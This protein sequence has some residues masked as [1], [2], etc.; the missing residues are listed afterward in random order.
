[1]WNF[2]NKFFFHK[3]TCNIIKFH[4][5]FSS[6]KV[7]QISQRA[8]RLSCLSSPIF[9]LFFHYLKAGAQYR[10]IYS[11]DKTL[12]YVIGYFPRLLSFSQMPT[13]LPHETVFSQHSVQYTETLYRAAKWCWVLVS[14]SDPKS[15]CFKH[16]LWPV[17]NSCQ[18]AIQLTIYI[19][20][21]VSVLLHTRTNPTESRLKMRKY[22]SRLLWA[23]AREDSISVP[24]AVAGLTNPASL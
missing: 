16:L 14:E 13:T 11:R 15:A 24:L 4:L 1:M 2:C 19:L 10:E 22:V 8:P 5:I 6:L 12:G 3:K 9:M 23:L 17:L 20:K 21:L 18:V 7:R